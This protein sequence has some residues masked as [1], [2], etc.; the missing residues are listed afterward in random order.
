MFSRGFPLTF[1]AMAV[2]LPQ[3]GDDPFLPIPLQFIIHVTPLFD[4]L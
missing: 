2:F 1:Q 3:I 4:A